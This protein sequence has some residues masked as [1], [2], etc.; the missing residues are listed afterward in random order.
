MNRDSISRRASSAY[1]I[2]ATGTGLVKIGYATNLA[3]RFSALQTSSP[4]KLKLLGSVEGGAEVEGELHFRF[5]AHRSH[6]EWFRRCE[7]IDAVIAASTPPETEPRQRM[8]AIKA[9]KGTNAA[10]AAR[11]R[12]Q[13]K[14]QYETSEAGLRDL[15]NSAR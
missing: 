13:L 15:L 6:G 4:V 2:E 11:I 8:T 5:A 9:G 1:F 10:S 14:T 3:A 7:E 12:R